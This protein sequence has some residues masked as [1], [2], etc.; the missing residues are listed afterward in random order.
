MHKLAFT[1]EMHFRYVPGFV[2]DKAQMQLAIGCD[3]PA[4]G[5]QIKLDMTKRWGNRLL[6]V[7]R[8]TGY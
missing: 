3:E 8:C 2:R 5:G 4:I 7:G 6:F 1:S